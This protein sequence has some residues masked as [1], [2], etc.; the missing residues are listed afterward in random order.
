M[1]MHRD[2]IPAKPHRVRQI[3]RFLRRVKQSKYPFGSGGSGLQLIYDIGGLVD[4]T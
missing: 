4:R 1:T 3:G 2:A